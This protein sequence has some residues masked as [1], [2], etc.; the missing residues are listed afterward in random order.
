M[1][2]KI[3]YI[4]DNSQK[5]KIFILFFISLPL[6]F[7]ETISIGSIP[8]YILSV[9]DPNKILEFINNDTLYNL[10]NNLSIEERSF[11]GLIIILIIFI[12]KGF[13]NLFFNYVEVHTIKKI[14][15]EHA[16]KVF[17]YYLKQDLLFHIS[18]NQSKLIQNVDDVKRSSSVI[19]SVF[20]IF[21][22]L[23]IIIMLLTML[24]FV[25]IKILLI[26]FVTF[27][28]PIIFF[29][30]FFKKR[31]KLRGVI[32][33]EHRVLKLKYLQESFSLIKF[34]KMIGGEKLTLD[35]FKESNYR[36]LH[37]EMIA[38]FINRTPKILLETFSVI[39]IVLIFYLL[40]QT[41]QG[42]ESI[43]PLITLL[44]VSLMRFIPSTG[45]ILMAV[46]Q[47][48]FHYVAVEN[49]YKIFNDIKNKDNENQS[50]KKSKPQKMSFNDSIEFKNIS[51]KYPNT[52]NFILK[53]ID[54]K[55][56]KNQKLG[57]TGVSGSGKSTLLSLFLGLLTPENGNL[58]CDKVNIFNN[59][60]GW[61]KNIGY[62]PQSINLLDDTIK[63]N[64]CFGV[65]EKNIDEKNLSKVI[66]MAELEDFI[67]KQDKKLE[68]LIG[69][70]GSRI[71]GGQLQRI[72]IARSLYLNPSILVL[73]EPTSALDKENEEQIIKNLF[74][75]KD[76]TIILIS[77]NLNILKEC[78]KVITLE[79]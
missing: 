36:A 33:K 38:T 64:I 75:I 6:I 2:K 68:T 53:K 71:S 21:K 79:N 50:F 46:N 67:F 15:I 69:Q 7:L 43:L 31:L 42:F 45:S 56:K 11:Y 3:F 20:N 77:H 34:I 18:N 13:Y 63:K 65:N 51:F 24:F 14:N 74:S 37:H 28:L 57:I 59:L 12:F 73:D 30:N 27:S 40:F 1:I 78:D 58:L 48:K 55:I 19:L 4:L 16:N 29:L 17:S 66:K 62:V 61:Q 41:N 9:I 39:S 47:Y 54:F 5:Q 26:L 10:V 76:V 23:F 60:K 22:D 49:I 72:G 25:S 52:E 70:N 44:V 35:Y 8:V 32:A